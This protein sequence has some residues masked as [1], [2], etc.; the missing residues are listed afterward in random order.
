MPKPKPKKDHPFRTPWDVPT[1]QDLRDAEIQRRRA[2]MLKRFR[3]EN[4]GEKPND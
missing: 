3:Q 1:H 4:G 2:E